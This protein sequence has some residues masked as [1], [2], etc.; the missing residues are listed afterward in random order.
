MTSA[1]LRRLGTL[2]TAGVAAVAVSLVAGPAEAYIAEP[3]GLVGTYSYDESQST[4]FATCTYAG[5]QGPDNWIWLN[6]L[7]VKAPTVLA[8]DRSSDHRDKRTVTF[9]MKIQRAKFDA[10]DSW[11]DVASS[12]VQRA[13]AYDD[14]AAPL[15][16]IKL[17]FTPRKTIDNGQS[18]VFRTKVIIRWLKRDGSVEGSVKI[19]PTYYKINSPWLSQPGSNQEHCS[20]VSTN[21]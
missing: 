9:Q 2:G 7:R 13:T 17:F 14:E 11:T 5:D 10:T 1:L 15:S 4:P 6:W 12:K 8:A 21:G 19:W 20:A 3:S 18:A 16:P